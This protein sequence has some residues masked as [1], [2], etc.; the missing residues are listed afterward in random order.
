MVEDSSETREGKDKI[1]RRRKLSFLSVY[2]PEVF[3]FFFFF[4]FFFRVKVK[5]IPEGELI[6]SFTFL[7]FPFG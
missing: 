1:E 2:S 5:L 7:M 4:F 6:F 3:W